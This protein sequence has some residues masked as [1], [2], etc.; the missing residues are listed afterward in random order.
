MAMAL[1]WFCPRPS[2][3]HHGEED[4]EYVVGDADDFI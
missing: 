1:C 2:P 3:A 4:Q